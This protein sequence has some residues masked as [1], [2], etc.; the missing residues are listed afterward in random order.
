MTY[1][2]GT[3]DKTKFLLKFLRNNGK[4]EIGGTYTAPLLAFM[5][6]PLKKRRM[7][8]AVQMLWLFRASDIVG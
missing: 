3:S 5:P 4:R 2:Q 6:A 7:M 8:R 1:K